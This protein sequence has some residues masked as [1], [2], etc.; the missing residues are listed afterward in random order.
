MECMAKIYKILLISILMFASFGKANS[1]SLK[2]VRTDV[3]SS[4]S[5]FVTATY[6]FG[7]DILTE[8]LD[9][10]SNVTFEL[11][12]D[13]TSFVRFS[14]WKKGEFGPSTKA[15]VLPL[16][17]EAQ[18]LGRI[19]V[20]CGLDNSLDP[21]APNN[22]KVVTLKFSVIPAAPHFETVNFTIY[23]PRATV[24]KDGTPQIVELPETKASYTIHSFVNVYPGDADNNGVVDHLDFATVSYYLGMGPNTKQMRS[25]KREPASTLWAPQPVIAWDTAAATFA[26]TDGN[27]E[28]NM[29][30]NL[31][32][33]YNYDK[34]HPI[35]GIP[36][37]QS[38]IF[39]PQ[40]ILPR[41]EK[42]I[43][44]PIYANTYQP[45][46]AASGSINL[47]SYQDYEIVGVEPAGLLDGDEL[48][49]AFANELQG[50]LEFIVGTVDKSKLIS[51]DGI[52]ANL[53]LEPK[54][55][56]SAIVQSDL[57]HL[58]GISTGGNIFELSAFTSIDETENDKPT[59]AKYYS[60]V[61]SLNGVE[62]Q[63]SNRLEIFGLRGELIFASDVEISS[64]ELS[65]YIPNLNS[66]CYFVRISGSEIIH[67][68]FWVY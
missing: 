60:N 38:E 49:F 31:V 58:K 21:N 68:P 6:I 19:V 54:N 48:A 26:D 52:I 29:T 15:Y 1:Q 56:S 66:G 23:N 3:D 4:R 47:S 64:S 9:S 67:L 28:V 39:M 11:R 45:Y 12:F 50:N 10:C 42:T 32:V 44:M 34:R 5:K 33:T 24:W 63:G 13:H 59:F 2:F 17:N 35:S 20:S 7:F 27:G 25:F 16:T 22:P 53:L 41:T 62:S 61:L 43:I 30:D 65:I 55:S 14:E 8:D 36:T 46:L 18:D 37:V 57:S 51:R 40:N